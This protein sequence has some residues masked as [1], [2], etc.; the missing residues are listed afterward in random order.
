LQNLRNKFDE[1]KNLIFN[2]NNNIN[3]LQNNLI[4]FNKIII[5][6]KKEMAALEKK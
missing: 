5:E 4:I 6:G 2:L 3:N 1:Q